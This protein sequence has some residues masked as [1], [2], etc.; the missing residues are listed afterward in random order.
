MLLRRDAPGDR[1]HARALLN[2]ALATADKLELKALADR[3]RQLK[4]QAEAQP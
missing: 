4:R 3:A 2:A 1:E